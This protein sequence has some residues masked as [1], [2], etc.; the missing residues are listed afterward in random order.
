MV[1]H[2]IEDDIVENDRRG[3]EILLYVL[4]S[5]G[6]LESTNAKRNKCDKRTVEKILNIE[7]TDDIINVVCFGS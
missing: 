7:Q 4:Y 3:K 1:V 5:A 6:I 2:R